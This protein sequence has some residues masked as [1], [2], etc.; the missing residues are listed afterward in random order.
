[1]QNE[2]SEAVCR[3][4]QVDSIE[5]PAQ[6]GEAPPAP[7]CA[8]FFHIHRRF[9]SAG[10][11][12]L[13][14]DQQPLS[15]LGVTALPRP[16]SRLGCKSVDLMSLETR[17]HTTIPFD[18]IG[19]NV[20]RRYGF[21]SSVA[22]LI[23]VAVGVLVIIGWL[24][25]IRVLASV[26]PDYATIKVNT[27]VCFVLAGLSLWLL[28]HPSV[29]TVGFHPHLGRMGQICALLVGF[30]G[31]VTIGEYC[32]RLNLGIDE[33]LLRDTWTDIRISPPGRMSIATAFEFFALGSS[34]LFLGRKRVDDIIAS[35]ILALSV[36]V[37]AVFACVGYFYG[38]HGSHAI[39]IYTTMAV[40][41]ACILVVLSLGILFARPERGAISVLTRAHNG[42]QMALLTLPLALT[43]PF[44]IGWLQLKGQQVGLYG[45]EFGLAFFATSNV[46]LF[47][48]LFWL[49]TKPLNRRTAESVQSSDRYRFLADAMP[50]IVWTA[51]P[52]GVLDYFNQR[53]FDYTGMTIEQTK[54][55]GWQHVIHPDDLQNCLDRWT[56]AFTTAC[57]FEVECRL[58]RGS[59]GAY[60]WHLGRAFPLRNQTGNIVQW[61][62]S[63]TDIDDQKRARASLEN[64]PRVS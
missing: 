3:W 24:L 10:P 11:A 60:R 26:I 44:L 34:L 33:A 2:I 48:F 21:I 19:P 9:Q 16:R 51:K 39:S 14:V 31:L 59:D 32:L 28:R 4:I 6:E 61:V 56:E 20:V 5:A 42:R 1:L 53:W 23:V 30:V 15:Y 12:S 37:A 17:M 50:Q 47:T 22:G 46:I 35:Q 63:C 13:S 8:A 52:D 62:G 58:K 45:T 40:H 57:D 38:D 18:S 43:L 29:Q 25:G 41:T 55:W 64:R 7:E 49:S 27:A 54:D 36:L